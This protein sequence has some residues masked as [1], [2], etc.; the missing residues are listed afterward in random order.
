MVSEELRMFA[1]PTLHIVGADPAGL[2]NRL[3]YGR[4]GN[5]GFRLLLSLAGSGGTWCRCIRELRADPKV[6]DEGEG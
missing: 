6:C 4:L 2:V 5:P 1:D 3:L